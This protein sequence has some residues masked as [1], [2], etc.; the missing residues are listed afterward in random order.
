VENV[1]KS[2]IKREPSKEIALLDTMLSA[3]VEIL[4]KK[5]NLDARGI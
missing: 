3:L 4:E 5:G 2:K 1:K